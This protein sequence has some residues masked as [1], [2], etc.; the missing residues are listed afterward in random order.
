MKRRMLLRD[1]KKYLLNNKQ[2]QFM[3]YTENQD[4]FNPLDPC[5]IQITFPVMVVSENPNLICLK[6]DIG[7]FCLDQVRFVE[8][9][10]KALGFGVVITVCCGGRAP[11]PPRITYKLIAA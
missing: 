4:W 1:F 9:D 11:N 10:T 6:S 7:T 3:F 5:K 2:Q 8:I